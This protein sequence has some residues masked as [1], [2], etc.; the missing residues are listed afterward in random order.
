MAETLILNFDS[1][2]WWRLAVGM[3]DIELLTASIR[4]P[5]TKKQFFLQYIVTFLSPP[6]THTQKMFRWHV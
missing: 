1:S 6:P 4:L 3:W 5:G 2:K